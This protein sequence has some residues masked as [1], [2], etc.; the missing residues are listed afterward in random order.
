MVI[1]LLERNNQL[2]LS[3]NDSGLR[4]GKE[5][6]SNEKSF[7]HIF[8]HPLLKKLDATII[9]DGHTG[10]SVSLAIN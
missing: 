6:F 1:D 9:F 10:I 7:D 3:V 5:S 8:V 2:L 4:M